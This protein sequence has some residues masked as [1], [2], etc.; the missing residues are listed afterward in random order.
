LI[1]GPLQNRVADWAAVDERFASEVIDGWKPEKKYP[2]VVVCDAGIIKQLRPSFPSSTFL[3]VGHGLISK[4]QPEYHYSGADYVC[5]SSPEIAQRLTSFGQIPRQKYLVTGLV[6]TDPLFSLKQGSEKMR[7][8]S[9]AHTVLYAPTW[10]PTLTSGHLLGEDLVAK[11][12]GE[13]ASIRILIRPHP[14]LSVVSKELVDAWKRISETEP[15]VEFC[16][17]DVDLVDCALVSD[18]IVSDASSAIFHFLALNRPIVLFDNPERFSDPS[19]FDPE[20]IEWTW[21]DIA[22]C[23]NSVEELKELV[24]EGLSKPEKNSEARTRRRAQLFGN[25]TDGQSVERVNK[26][27]RSFLRRLGGLW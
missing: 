15:N 13:D 5:V 26:F 27:I 8:T 14:H 24:I 3:H 1:L 9:A 21:R 20:G 4:N 2:L 11:L 10:N 6:Q 17:E 23:T 18:L 12:R 16:D 22:D 19:C 7:S 25:L